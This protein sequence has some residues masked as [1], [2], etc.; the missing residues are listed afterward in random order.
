MIQQT[1]LTVMDYMVTISGTLILLLLGGIGYFLRQFASSVRDLKIT[2]DQLRLVLSVEQEKI[3]NIKE[4][5]IASLSNVDIKLNV[6]NVKVDQHDKDIT[7]LKTIH[8]GKI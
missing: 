3:H 4:T 8:D 6:L 2:V 7:V 5:L 1:D